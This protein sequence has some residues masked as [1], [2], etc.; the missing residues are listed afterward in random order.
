MAKENDCF[1]LGWHVFSGDLLVSGSV[2]G[3]FQ[4]KI[5]TVVFRKFTVVSLVGSTLYGGDSMICVRLEGP[6]HYFNAICTVSKC[7]G[8]LYTRTDAQVASRLLPKTDFH[9]HGSSIIVPQGVEALK[10]KA[11]QLGGVAGGDG[12]IWCFISMI[13]HHLISRGVA[14]VSEI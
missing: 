5:V 10:E 8:T 1:L 7:P 9:N 6:S 13:E 4:G 3:P 12:W 11:W 2:I 14:V